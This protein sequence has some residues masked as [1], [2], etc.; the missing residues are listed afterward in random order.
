MMRVHVT[1]PDRRVES[2]AGG[3]DDPAA[4]GAATAESYTADPPSSDRRQEE[5][6]GAPTAARRAAAAAHTAATAH[7][8]TVPA[9]AGPGLAGTQSFLR[10]EL[11]V[12]A[13]DK[14]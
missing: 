11:L 9:A 12:V 10:F 5:G 13:G 14:D 1:A 3:A 2:E 4:P 8:E 6:L 7:A